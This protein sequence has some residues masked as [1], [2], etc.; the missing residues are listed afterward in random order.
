MAG[1][2]LERLAFNRAQYLAQREAVVAEN[3][4]NVDTPGFRA[5]DLPSFG[6]VLAASS[7]NAAAGESGLW[8]AQ[9]LREFV[10]PAAGSDDSDT[11]SG[12]SVDIDRQM[13]ALSEINKAYAL[14]SNITRA[15]NQMFTAVAK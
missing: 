12:N 9:S 15:F 13:S 7:S 4:A 3:V 1:V 5:R 2:F 14:T 11:L 10:S 8:S 6:D